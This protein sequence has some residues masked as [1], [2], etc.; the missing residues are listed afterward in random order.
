MQ[1]MHVFGSQRSD[2]GQLFVRGRRVVDADRGGRSDQCGERLAV[3]G[4]AAQ[5][6]MQGFGLSAQ[7][8]LQSIGFDQFVNQRV[9][10]G[11][12]RVLECGERQAEVPEP[13]RGDPVQPA[14][15]R[16]LPPVEFGEQNAAEH[17][18]V[19][20]PARPADP[21]DECVG[22]VKP[23]EDLAGISVPCQR[24]GQFSRDG[25]ANA[26]RPQELVDPQ[27]MRA[28]YLLGEIVG[29]RRVLS[30]ESVEFCGI[31]GF[32]AEG[33][34]REPQR[35]RPSLGPPDQQVEFGL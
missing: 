10:P 34:G 28:E 14:P 30:G 25:F 27:R 16:W 35:G 4:Q 2:R 21:V 20:I 29:Q 26:G 5:H 18:V 22:P 31:A 33:H 12:D 9:V 6:A 15:D 3:F 32:L 11:G 23:V 13:F 17:R 1:G 19:A 24:G 7:D 8:L